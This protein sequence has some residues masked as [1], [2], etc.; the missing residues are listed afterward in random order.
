MSR[1]IHVFGTAEANLQFTKLIQPVHKFTGFFKPTPKSPFLFNQTE[2]SSSNI[3]VVDAAADIEVPL[4]KPNGSEFI[5]V[6]LNA[7]K[8]KGRKEDVIERIRTTLEGQL[9]AESPGFSFDDQVYSLDDEAT[10]ARLKSKL[11]ITRPA[12][13][14]VAMASPPPPPP[15][16]FSSFYSTHHQPLVAS[17]GDLPE[18][19]PNSVPGSAQHRPQ[20]EPQPYYQLIFS[21]YSVSDYKASLAAYIDTQVAREKLKGSPKALA[22]GD[23]KTGIGVANDIATLQQI[24]RDIR[25][26]VSQ[27][28]D[29]LSRAFALIAPYPT[30]RREF[31][32]VFNAKNE[33]L[34]P[35][36]PTVAKDFIFAGDDAH[37]AVTTFNPTHGI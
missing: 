17:S 27:H 36:H 6:I 13:A 28:R 34:T 15:P 23:F 7:D 24:V 26:L 22:L 25:T 20:P 18:S 32:K 35:P 16:P 30:S 4:H 2:L 33:L 9:N 11:E 12:A 21:T 14:S 1:A 29:A 10:I 8:A 5:L 31:D 37:A 3:F 19:A